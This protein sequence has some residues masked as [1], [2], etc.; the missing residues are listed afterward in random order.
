MSSDHAIEAT[1]RENQKAETDK[2]VREVMR[3]LLN[4]F[5]DV[6]KM[7]TRRND[8]CPCGSGKKFKRCCLKGN[9]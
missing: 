5:G 2:I 6:P 4:P 1:A 8:P 7:R 3:R 9:Q